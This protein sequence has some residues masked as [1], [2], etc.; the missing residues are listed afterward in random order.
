MMGSRNERITLA[1]GWMVDRTSF[2]K[3][4]NKLLP[5][6][7]DQ[8]PEFGTAEVTPMVKL[9]NHYFVQQDQ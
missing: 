2:Y 6:L 4:E 8:P 1:N 5:F 9:V 3:E 7:W